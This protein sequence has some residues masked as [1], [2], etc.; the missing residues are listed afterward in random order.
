MATAPAL[1]VPPAG[2]SAAPMQEGR[3]L[4]IARGETVPA[5]THT[6][7]AHE[8]PVLQIDG[9]RLWYGQKQAL[10]DINM[11][12]PE[13]KVTALVGPSGCGK[14][15]LLRSVNRLNDLLSTVRIE[16]EMRLNGDSI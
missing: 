5:E 14:S 9:F 15:T 4:A 16:G 11:V 8:T 3:L 7:L 10:Y 6:A 1:S 12:I 13:H 2:E